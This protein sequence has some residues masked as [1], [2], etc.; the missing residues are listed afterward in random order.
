MVLCYG[1]YLRRKREKVC[2]RHDLIEDLSCDGSRY[3]EGL[4]Y[5]CFVC[6]YFQLEIRV[7]VWIPIEILFTSIC[8]FCP[9]VARIR[10][11]ILFENLGIEYVIDPHFLKIGD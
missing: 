2:R 1:C 5:H 6:T 10:L 3:L 11:S 9:Q 7:R 4:V 8:I